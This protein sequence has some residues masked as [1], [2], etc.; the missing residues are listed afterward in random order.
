MAGF[1]GALLTADFVKP[2]V[3]GRRSLRRDGAG[4]GDV[5]PGEAIGQVSG[6]D[7]GL[8]LPGFNVDGGDFVVGV[9]GDVGDEAVGTDEYLLRLG[10]N[11]DGADDGEIGE[12]DDGNLG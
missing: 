4:C 6:I 8:A 2:R 3:R 7:E 10:G 1:R 12:I 9:A 5:R 11:V